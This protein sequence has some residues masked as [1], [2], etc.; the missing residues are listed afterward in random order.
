MFNKF[1]TAALSAMI[2]LGASA[3]PASAQADG[4]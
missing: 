1:R 3:M 4:L 2:G